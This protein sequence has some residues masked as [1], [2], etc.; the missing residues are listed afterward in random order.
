MTVMF[1]AYLCSKGLQRRILKIKIQSY[2]L[3]G[4]SRQ[5]NIIVALL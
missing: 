4:Y 3:L 5:I 1:T 2:F